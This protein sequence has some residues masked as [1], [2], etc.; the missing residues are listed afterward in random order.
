MDEW[1]WTWTRNYA[2]E[3]GKPIWGTERTYIRGIGGSGTET[4]A[5]GAT[6]LIASARDDPVL[7]EVRDDV[8]TCVLPSRALFQ[9]TPEM[10]PNG[11]EGVIFAYAE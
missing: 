6:L 3:S 1:T 7:S 8:S 2:A 5:I 11:G 9:N 4:A 10:T